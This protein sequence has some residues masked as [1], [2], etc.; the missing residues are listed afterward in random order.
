MKRYFNTGFSEGGLQSYFRKEVELLCGYILVLS[1]MLTVAITA[2]ILRPGD[3]LPT[4]ALV[5][6]SSP[7]WV[8][9]CFL[10][11]QLRRPH[12]A[13]LQLLSY[14]FVYMQDLLDLSSRLHW[15]LPAHAMH[16]RRWHLMPLAIAY[17]YA[18]RRQRQVDESKKRN[19]AAVTLDTLSSK[20]RKDSK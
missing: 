17:V 20:L 7:L 18:S 14:D 4:F 10:Y 12:T 15:P 16:Y 3:Q 11:S 19:D 8:F 6:L 1:L 13:V 5:I 2:L 9:I